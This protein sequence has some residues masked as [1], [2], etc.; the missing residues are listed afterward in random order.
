MLVT[1]EN[2]AHVT[3]IFPGKLYCSAPYQVQPAFVG[4][5][6]KTECVNQSS[7]ANV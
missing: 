5:R 7:M 2:I 1:L 6:L 4:S 3:V